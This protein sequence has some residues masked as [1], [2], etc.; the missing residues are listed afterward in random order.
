MNKKELDAI[1][2]NGQKRTSKYEPCKEEIAYLYE[3]NATLETISNFLFVKYQIKKTNTTLH[4]FIH[5][6]ISKSKRITKK[7]EPLK[8]D[9]SNNCNA[10]SNNR[11][12][13]N[14]S[15]RQMAK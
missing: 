9:E 8:A 3:N 7:I 1:L 5:R 2:K 4:Y 11:Y 12:T 15:K 14:S 6:H 13:M 10:S